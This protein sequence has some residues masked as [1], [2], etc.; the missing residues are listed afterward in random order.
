MSCYWVESRTFK[1]W[2]WLAEDN[3]SNKVLKVWSGFLISVYSKMQEES[4]TGGKK[5]ML[6]EKESKKEHLKNLQ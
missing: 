2:T 1:H 6:G 5:K 3:F 4:D